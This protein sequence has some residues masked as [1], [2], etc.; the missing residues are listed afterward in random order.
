MTPQVVPIYREWIGTLDGFVN[1]QIRAQIS[2]Y[3][4]QQLYT[5]GSQVRK[6][7][8][9][10]EIDARTFEAALAQ[11]KGK[12]AQDQAQVSRTQWDVER[13]AP[14]AEQ[15]A[16]SQRD[17]NTALQS[18]LSA[19]AQVKADQAVVEAAELNLG[20]THILSPIDGVAGLALA[21]IGD[22]VGPSGPPLT[23]VS[24]VDPIKVFFDVSEQDYLAYHLR[25]TNAAA[26]T[27]HEQELQLQLI[28]ADG[29]TY[30]YGGR[31]LFVGREV[32]PGTG[33]LRL[34]GSFPNPERVLRPGQFA[35]VRART[36]LRSD[37]LLVPQRAVSELQG[38][39][40]VDTVDEQNKVHT[41]PVTLGEQVGS[42]WIVDNG[43]QPG[44]VSWSRARK[45][46]RKGC[47]S[48]PNPWRQPRLRKRG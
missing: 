6:G 30:G 39:Y 13:Y 17:Y 19:Q 28:L 46:S 15:N 3:L 37:A 1:A 21:Q 22:L 48:A 18:N 10:F 25:Y 11:A 26:R 38:G 31:F 33:T 14:L 32:N 43:L 5:E 24:T 40:Q 20:F 2:G 45:R 36:Q 7:D 23:T 29:S 44:A 12:L 16:I 47:G 4:Q 42:Q 8:S 34:A 27:A 41:Q 9:L 35:R